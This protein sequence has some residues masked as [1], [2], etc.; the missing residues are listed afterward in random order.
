MPP[1]STSQIYVIISDPQITYLLERVLRSTGYAVTVLQDKASADPALEKAVPDLVI[2]GD[3]LSDSSGLDIARILSE[4][5][6]AV[7]VLMFVS[8]DT[9]DLLKAALR[10]GVSDYICLPLRSDD[11]LKAV[12]KSLQNAQ[13]MRDWIMQE[14]R[15]ATTN[16]QQKISELEV[17]ARLGHSITSSLD[18]DSVLSAIVDAAVELTG[19]EEGSLL[20]LDELTGD[21]YMRAARNFQEDFV[22]TFRL[23]ITDSLAGSVIKTGKPVMLDESTPQKI[24]TSYL[25]QGLLYVPLQIHGHVFGVLGV[26]NRKSRA[27]FTLH[28]IHLVT[29][30]AEYAVIAIENARLYTRTTTDHQKLELILTSIQDGVLVIDNEGRIV[31]V[32]EVVKSAF[33]LGDENLTGKTVTDIILQ[34]ELLELISPPQ[35][36]L[37]THAEIALQDGRILNAQTTPIPD[38]GLAVTMTD[39]T[40]LKKLDR[41]KSDFV[42]TVSHDLRSP[43]T[44]ILGYVDLIER[45]GPTND[46]QREFINR[47]QVSVH[48]I[49]S[50]VDDL[51]NLGKIE[52]GFDSRKEIVQISHL[53]RYA[54]E[55]FSSVGNDKNQ[56]LLVEIPEGFPPV[57]G[58]PVQLRQA[59]DNLLDNAVKYTPPEGIIRVHGEVE[60]N[61][62]ILQVIDNGIGIPAVDLP[63]IFDKFFRASNISPLV[64]GTGLG[65]AIVK[66]IVE[67]HAGRVWVESTQDQG[68]TFTIVLPVVES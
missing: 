7:P 66:S 43:L 26:D 53:I 59:I 57:F 34:P 35:K 37:S 46:T 45:V 3:K 9:P 29:A 24:K 23:P 10:A 47:V 21:L 48:N 52:A 40:Y 36:S 44:A 15:R 16:L 31:L 42:G 5:F 58:N 32:N 49:T 56:S 33:A 1:N 39:I 2:V 4:R 50:L 41:I 17:M 28:H 68:S 27:P 13:R 63:Y 14:A 65:L 60:G 30:M 38:V 12:Q 11:I 20:L 51:L 54:A 8:Q 18:L 62:I 64:T 6:P 25:V 61:Q 22:R 19:A 55:E 67:S